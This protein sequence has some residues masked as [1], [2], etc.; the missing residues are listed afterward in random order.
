MFPALANETVIPV[1]V[2]NTAKSKKGLFTDMAMKIKT[3]LDE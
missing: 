3:G 1:P 2:I